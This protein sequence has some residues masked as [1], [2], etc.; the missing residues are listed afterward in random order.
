MS[1]LCCAESQELPAGEHLS[2]A[3]SKSNGALMQSGQ[4]STEWEPLLSLVVF[5]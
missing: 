5:M 4:C 1:F 2:V 3:Q